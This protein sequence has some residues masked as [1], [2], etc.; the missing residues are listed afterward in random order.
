MPAIGLGTWKSAPGEVYDAVKAAVKEGYRHIDC[1]FLY[2]NEAEIG[3]ALQDLFAEGTVTREQ[4]WI[5]SKLWNDSHGEGHLQ[6][7]IEKTLSDLKLDWLDLYLI[8][9][10]VSLKA[11]TALPD[12]GEDILAPGEM[13]MT[14]VWGRMENLVDKGLTRH[15]GVSNFSAKK[16]GDIVKTARIKPEMNQVEMHPYLQQ[17]A[18]V[19]F[20]RENGVHVTAYSPLGSMDRPDFLKQEDEPILLED[21][22]IREIA[23]AHDAG[24]AQ[25]LLAWAVQRGTSVIPKSVNPRRLAENLAAGQ[26]TL[27]DAEMQSIAGLDRHRR[28]IVGDI[29]TQQGSPY[30]LATLWDE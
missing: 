24:P 28:Y 26:L 21:P 22:V 25:V 17:Q 11:G 12:S 23:Q 6:P 4:M 19:N 3:R 7:A 30:T 2:G 16:V 5:T 18:L 20:C 27:S 13:P 14:E 10:P 8:H 15:I 1:A 9:W 29:W